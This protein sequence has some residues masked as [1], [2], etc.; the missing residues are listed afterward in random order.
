MLKKS[1]L[2]ILIEYINLLLCR[3]YKSLNYFKLFLLDVG[4]IK[5]IAGLTNKPILLSESFQFKGQL[6]ENY[7]LEQLIPLL[8]NA[9]N[10]YAFAQER[11]IDF[12]LQHGENII[13]V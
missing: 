10:F 3:V 4:L 9:P 13:P 1:F 8:D 11:E 12:V 7:G 2:L 6:T 5:H